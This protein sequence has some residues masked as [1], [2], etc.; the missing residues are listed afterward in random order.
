MLR[1]KLWVCAKV[2][3]LCQTELFL[4]GAKH[5]NEIKSFVE[6]K[7]ETETDGDGVTKLNLMKSFFKRT[8][9]SS[10]SNPAARRWTE[11]RRTGEPA[12][13]TWDVTHLIS[14][15]RKTV[16]SLQCKMNKWRVIMCHNHIYLGKQAFNFVSKRCWMH[17]IY[18]KVLRL[19]DN[20]KITKNKLQWFKCAMN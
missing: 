14:V 15:I 4:Q 9:F 11:N 12:L 5:S 20:K 3:R 2:R 16:W 19:H 1:L 6:M 18:S 10:S 8:E 17:G 7:S 13:L